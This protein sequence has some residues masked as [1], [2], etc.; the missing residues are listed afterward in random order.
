MGSKANL[1]Q[2]LQLIKKFV[3]HDECKTIDKEKSKT[4]SHLL[5]NSFNDIMVFQED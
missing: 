1:K 5:F 3:Y 4:Q 2:I